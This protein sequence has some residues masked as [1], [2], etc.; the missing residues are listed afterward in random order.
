MVFP[1][2][3]AL[4]VWGAPGWGGGGAARRGGGGGR[5]AGGVG[6]GLFS[7][8]IRVYGTVGVRYRVLVAWGDPGEMVG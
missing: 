8:H 7:W 2:P 5:G 3:S 1:A 4:G 6:A